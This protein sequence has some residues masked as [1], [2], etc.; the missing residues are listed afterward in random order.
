M[1]GKASSEVV[2][3]TINK[4][5]SNVLMQ[6]SQS[7]SQ[8]NSLTQDISFE[9]IKAADGCS[10]NFS[11]I[12]QTA[13]Q[14][15]NFT[16]S[17]D[18]KNESQLATAFKTE[19]QQQSEAAL[20]GVAL[21]AEVESEI[22]NK[23]VN[24][25]TANINISQVSS[26]VQDNLAKQLLN[27]ENISGSC[28]IY[29]R[30]PTICKD[31]PQICDM[32]KCEITFKDISQSL[33]QEAVGNCLS[34]N[35]AVNQIVNDVSNKTQQKSSSKLEGIDPTASSAVASIGLSICVIVIFVLIFL[36]LGGTGGATNVIQAAKG[37]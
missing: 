26:C 13:I 21:G 6:S 3:D 29:C 36:F 35:T 7:C 23:L 34:S 11:G 18:S 22:K 25:I 19:L 24:D 9:K 33:T 20:K 10:L 32:D 27:F 14:S 37:F 5:V 28:P 31:V 30:N 17:S 2:N 1:G 4:S 15:P 12:S 16:C 8:N